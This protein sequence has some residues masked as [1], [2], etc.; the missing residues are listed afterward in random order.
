MTGEKKRILF[1]QNFFMKNKKLKNSLLAYFF[2]Q[3]TFPFLGNASCL[4]S[5]RSLQ[6]L[7][8]EEAK[9][10]PEQ[11]IEDIRHVW[12]FL[13]FDRQVN[14][15][16][17]QKALFAYKNQSRSFFNTHNFFDSDLLH[18][19]VNTYVTGILDTH[20]FIKN[21]SQYEVQVAALKKGDLVNFGKKRFKLGNFLGRGNNTHIW[22]IEDMPG[23]VLRVPFSVGKERFEELG[24]FKIFKQVVY[25]EYNLRKLES[26][27]NP[28]QI[29]E[30]DPQFRF[31]ITSNVQG[32]LD[33][34][35]LLTKIISES[36]D[37]EENERKFWL[38]ISDM[39]RDGILLSDF[40]M[41]L[42]YVI[43]Q[44]LKI[45]LNY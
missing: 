17:I 29:K 13:F 14:S 30:V 22:E 27:R 43:N 18:G 39:R 25:R 3:L 26:S 5:L 4:F 1:S 15:S 10:Q 38:L 23:Y 34:V 31:I 21:I 24:P 33:G 2:V 41:L 7:H 16:N 32:T 12:P 42:M 44:K 37:R 19:Q 11:E 20:N 45:E 36:V 35:T 28:V 8:Q 6:A 40:F 9:Y